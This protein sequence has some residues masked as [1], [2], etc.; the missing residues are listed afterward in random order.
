VAK[1]LMTA[2]GKPQQNGC[3]ESFNGRL[4]DGLLNEP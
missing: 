1:R 3:N 2:P 4:R